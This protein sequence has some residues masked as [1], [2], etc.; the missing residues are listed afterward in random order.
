M[1]LL[2]KYLIIIL[3]F[4][5]YG[6]V[7]SIT[8]LFPYQNDSITITY[9]ASL[10]NGELTGISPVFAHTGLI[11][12]TSS[13]W[14]NVQG[15]W[16]TADS[17]VLMQSSGNDLHSISFHIPSY[18]GIT[19]TSSS[20]PNALAFVFRNT[21]GTLVGRNSDQS[22]IYVPIYSSSSPLEVQWASHNNIIETL[23]N[24]SL[25]LN[26][27][28]S[29]VADFKVFVDGNLVFIDSNTR[30]ITPTINIPNSL[31]I[32]S[33][34]VQANQGS[35]SVTDSIILAVNNA[36]GVNQNVIIIP[37]YPT[38][39]DTIDIV[40]DSLSG[41][42]GT[43]GYIPLYLHTGI[44]TQSSGANWQNVQ[45]NWGTDDNNVRLSHLGGGIWHKRLHVNS[46]YAL[47]SIASSAT[48][49]AMVVRDS[50]GNYVGKTSSGGD[51]LHPL[52]YSSYSSG[53]HAAFTNSSSVINLSVG[54]S[55]HL[56]AVS[57]LAASL[58]IMRNGSSIASASNSY[59]L[60][61]SLIT[62]TN[63]VGSQQVLLQAVNNTDTIFDT[64]NVYVAPETPVG[65]SILTV[66]PPFPL[67]TDTVNITYHANEGNG[68][69]ATTSPVFA[70][71]GMITNGNLNYWQNV[72][73]TWGIADSNVIMTS[74]GNASHQIEYH[75]P[76]FYGIS[77][78]STNMTHMS[79]VFRNT[80]GTLVGRN[81][82]GGDIY[83]PITTNP[84]A[85]EARFFSPTQV[86]VLKA[87]QC[88]NLKV[89]SNLNATLTLYDNGNVIATDTNTTALDFCQSPGGQYG[90]HMVTLMA[91]RNG[92][93]RRDTVYYVYPGNKTPAN[94]PLG[95]KN[96]ANIINDS[97]IT[98]V[99]YAPGKEN[100][101]V[102]AEGND[103]LP[104]VNYQ[105]TPSLDG[106]TY[107]ITLNC[108]P[109]QDF[110]YQYLVDGEIR[111]ADPFSER[112][113]DP[114]NDG[115]I[116]SANYPNPYPY[117]SNKTFGHCS[118]IHPGGTPFN[119]QNDNYQAPDKE[120]LMIYE[121]LVRDFV[122]ERNYNTIRDS[123]GYFAKLN[124][125]AIEF[126]PINEFENNLSWG[127]N[128]S[129][130]MALDKMYG[131]P[132]DF[133]SLV[134]SLHGRGIA[135]IVDVVLNHAEGQNPLARLWWDAV[136]N[137]PASDNP[138]FNTACPH[139]PNCWGN[140][141]NHESQATKDY[142]DQIL[143]YWI[144]E[145]HVDGFRLDFTKGFTNGIGG[146]WDVSRQNLLKRI[147]NTVWSY[148]PGAYLILEH[149]GDNSEEINLSNHGFMLWGNVCHEYQDAA[150]G[151][152]S[153]S[154]FSQ[155]FH[156]SRGWNNAG[157][158]TYVESHDEERIA[159]KNKTFGNNSIGNHNVRNTAISMKRMELTT[160]FGHL[161]PGPKMM[162][163]F[164]ELGYDISIDDPCRVCE[165]PPKWNYYTNV[166][167][168]RLYEITG[169]INNLKA[170]YPSFGPYTNF[171]A[172]MQGHVKQM[173]FEHS[174]MD[175]VAVGNFDVA[176]QT[177]D[178]YFSH[179]GTWYE[180]FT[181]QSI[182]INSTTT[183]LSLDAGEYRLYTDVNIPGGTSQFS[184]NEYDLE[185]LMVYPNPGYDKIYIE[186]LN[187]DILQAQYTVYDS[188][189]G[190]VKVGTYYIHHEIEISSLANGLYYIVLIDKN[191]RTYSSK[192]SKL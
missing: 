173:R 182:T 93:I 154:S 54:D 124:I 48:H 85:F 94:P 60:S 186:Y 25:T 144:E 158:V 100:V 79:F 70:H 178:I 117:P 157:L 185:D 56:Q 171:Y 109:N 82:D 50:S 13:N 191:N 145:Y 180:Y 104:D 114:Q 26:A 91:F 57:N 105:M 136:N 9:D 39:Q 138:Y 140:D 179:T 126:M 31:G 4:L 62:G 83:Y 35:Q 170:S 45:G 64:L 3:P 110:I 130:H 131:T 120:N 80:D 12:G 43:Q 174:T 38:N 155:A 34:V 118:L 5:G 139:P 151:F 2:T 116:P 67:K 123:L 103:F 36:V 69:L 162:Y 63:W 115:D 10:G 33:L 125:N 141:F 55:L 189:G 137:A 107:W 156:G 175:A 19:G 190:V 29:V 98:L 134:D 122:E 22:D 163:Q 71:T 72:Q 6:Q 146:G 59:G 149:W 41:N 73:G 78:S 23:P 135:V 90:N 65:G 183:S 37:A 168:R 188:H 152:G 148:K 58:N 181:G 84:N 177:K 51:I 87:G 111:I 101:F 27:G 42:R 66:V 17:S 132:N 15:N 187:S 21:S 161:I 99:L 53:F 147:A 7:V 1:R 68:S 113:L 8:P 75:I 88:L 95:L 176:S 49:L 129:Y 172:D 14:Q 76:S 143:R 32:H 142:V 30:S 108:S 169:I 28:S 119:W 112:I 160:L 46:F 81:I 97:T 121:L 18:Y 167:R 77:P 47:S 40:Y 20:G 128:P 150:M 166:P 153:N 11:Y 96:G 165:K 92:N 164:Q 44:L 106:S 159:F 102:L 16:G 133:K 61:H 127:Y 24:T 184:V 74:I 86:H 52:G 89:K 192:F